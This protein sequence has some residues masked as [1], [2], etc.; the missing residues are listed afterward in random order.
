MRAGHASEAPTGFPARP[1]RE[2]VLAPLSSTGSSH[3]LGHLLHAAPSAWRHAG[4]AGPAHRRR[5]SP[6]S[7]VRSTEIEAEIASRSSL[8]PYT[9]EFE[10]MF[11]FVERMLT[12]ARR[13]R[14]RRPAAH[15]ALAATT[16]TTRCSSLRSVERLDALLARHSRRGRDPYPPLARRGRNAD[17]RLHSRPAGAAD[18]IRPL[19]RRRSP[20]P[21]C[22]MSTACFR[23]GTWWTCCTMGAAAITTTGFPA[24]PRPHGGTARFPRLPVELLR[25]HRIERLHRRAYTR[26]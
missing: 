25:L 2:S 22:A 9:G 10:D 20:R 15:R 6:R 4:R 16:S 17:P 14:H 19:P 13:T 21:C 11:F 18:H 5:R 1:M 3:H 24:R 26:P 23:R 7:W 12:D 8:E